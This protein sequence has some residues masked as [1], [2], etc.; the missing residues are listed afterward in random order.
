MGWNTCKIVFLNPTTRAVQA[1]NTK[2]R[3]STKGKVEGQIN[4]EVKPS[5]IYT[6]RDHAKVLIIIILRTEC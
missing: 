5:A 3:Y 2:V 1:V 4:H 6:S